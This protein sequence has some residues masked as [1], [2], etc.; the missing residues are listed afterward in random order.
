MEVNQNHLKHLFYRFMVAVQ[1][2]ETFQTDSPLKCFNFFP[3]VTAPSDSK[4]NQKRFSLLNK[5]L[6]S[7]NLVHSEERAYILCCLD[8]AMF[9]VHHILLS[10]L[11]E[12]VHLGR[13]KLCS[14]Y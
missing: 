3:F 14:Y 2:F 11:S 4:L 13:V 12:I 6:L 5:A 7:T 8:T 1:K 10:V 9:C